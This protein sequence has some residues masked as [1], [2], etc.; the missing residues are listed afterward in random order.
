MAAAAGIS[1]HIGSNLEWDIATSAMC[2]LA[3][4]SPNV[5]VATYP[6]DILG[7]L[8]YKTRLSNPVKFSSGCVS[9]PDGPGL[10]L[11]IDEAEIEALAN[12]EHDVPVLAIAGG[13]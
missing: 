7:P 12:R 8:Y 2:Q 6:P 4:C 1:C 3:A 11:V 13:K 5:Q 9:V 10:G